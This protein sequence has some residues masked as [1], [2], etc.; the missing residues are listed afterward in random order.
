MLISFNNF[1]FLQAAYASK[2]VLPRLVITALAAL[3][4]SASAFAADT[5]DKV[6][7]AE[8][9]LFDT[10]HLKNLNQPTSILYHFK[11]DGQLEAGFEDQVKVDI[12]KV[13]AT[14]SKTASMRFLTGARKASDVPPVDDVKGN[15]VLLGFLE[16]DLI[17]MKRLTGGSTNYFRKRIRLALVDKASVKPTNFSYDGKEIKGKEV[18]VKPFIDD[19]MKQ[20]MEK[21]VNKQYVFLLSDQV[22]GGVYQVRSIVPLESVMAGGEKV[23]AA[24]DEAAKSDGK[25]KVEK[26]DPKARTLIE[27][28]MTLSK[29][30]KLAAK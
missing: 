9:I 4:L 3:T 23:E 14:G 8:T 6:S 19:P 7:E 21:Y 26:G 27:E 11:K 22:P 10:D 30:A 12:S 29:L 2:T 16:R 13:T 28:T 20:K 25:S 18:S 1:S 5:G 24:N 15:P 17:E